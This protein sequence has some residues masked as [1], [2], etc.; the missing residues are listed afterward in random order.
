MR[1]VKEKLQKTIKD[2][3]DK[4]IVAAYIF[5]SVADGTAHPDSDIDVLVMINKRGK[6]TDALVRKLDLKAGLPI[7]EKTGNNVSFHIYDKD[8][9]EKNKTA[10]PK[11]AVEKGIKVY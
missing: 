5:G 10:W 11:I 6:D 3:N 1:F 2:L 4:S 8:K 9:I 7:M